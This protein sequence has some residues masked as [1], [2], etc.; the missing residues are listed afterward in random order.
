[1][2]GNSHHSAACV[3]GLRVKTA[4]DC[5]L[6]D[7][8]SKH[9]HQSVSFRRPSRSVAGQIDASEDRSQARSSESQPPKKDFLRGR[10]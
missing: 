1:M 10:R 3:L 4:T 5:R 6:E 9:V 7:R 8:S 2:D